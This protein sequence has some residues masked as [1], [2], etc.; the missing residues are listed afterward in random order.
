MST[1]RTRQASSPTGLIIILLALVALL[2]LLSGFLTRT[3]VTRSQA[4]AQ[5][6]PSAAPHA[7]TTPTNTSAAIPSTSATGTVTAS[8]VTGQFQL[9]VSVTPKKVTPGQQ[10]TITVH[11][12]T[13]DTHTPIVGLPCILRAPTDGGPAL[14]STWPPAQTTDATGAATWSLTA[15]EQPAGTYEV[16]AYAK[17]SAWSYRL[18]S[19]VNLSAS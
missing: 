3:L 11:A 1:K 15:P 12:F 17:A 7:Q 14:F 2:G 13:P 4:S 8:T 5:V 9:S 10:M 16:E 6:S 18:D 19:T